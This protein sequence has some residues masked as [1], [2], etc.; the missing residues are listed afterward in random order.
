MLVPSPPP[1]PSPATDATKKSHVTQFGDTKGIANELVTNFQGNTDSLPSTTADSVGAMSPQG[2]AARESAT[3]DSRAAELQYAFSR[4]LQTES[5]DDAAVLKG[6]MDERLEVNARFGRISLAVAGRD[7][8]SMALPQK[9]NMSCQHE[10]L[11]AYYESCAKGRWTTSE[12]K[13]GATLAKLCTEV[14][15]DEKPIVAAI[16]AECKGR[17]ER[18]A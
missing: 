2:T 16:E 3:L 17:K 11:T 7:V 10:A 9:V 13:H 8:S 15:G 18:A 6:L 12:L 14:G 5:A 4:F 1:C